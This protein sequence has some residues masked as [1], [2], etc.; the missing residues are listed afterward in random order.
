MPRHTRILTAPLAAIAV[1][2]LVGAGAA[3]AHGGESYGGHEGHDGTHGE[4]WSADVV[5]SEEAT[6]TLGEAGVSVD[7]VEPAT[8]EV[9]E[10]GR[11]LLSFPKGD[12][13]GDDSAD[14]PADDT[15]YEKSGEHGQYGEVAFE[16]GVEY[17]SVSATTTWLEPTVDTADWTVSADVDGTR[18]DVFQLAVPDQEESSGHERG[19]SYAEH[20]T[21]GAHQVDLVLTADG[22][23][24]LNEV[25]GG[26]AFAEG[27][28]LAESAEGAGDNGDWR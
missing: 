24:A 28:V 11:T 22:A 7:A 25:A 12:D 26:D 10:D 2:G 14:D 23:E 15:S 8:A 17:S 1:T 3:Q 16:G 20:G 9:Q 27:D 4:S 13:A 18:V 21:D 19:A 5:T 6:A